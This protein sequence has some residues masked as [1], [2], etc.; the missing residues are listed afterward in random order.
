MPAPIRDGADL[1]LDG[2]ALPG[3][4]STV[5]DLRAYEADGAW[6]SCAKGADPDAA[7]V[8]AALRYVG[9]SPPAIGD[10]PMTDLPP[11]YFDR[12]LADVDPEVADALRARARAASSARSR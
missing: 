5:V 12:P 7:S 9:A 6:R 4:P 1:V 3:T 8:A 10:P 2:G 11:D